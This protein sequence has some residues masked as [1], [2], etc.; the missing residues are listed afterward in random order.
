MGD[1]NEQ[2]VLKTKLPTSFYCS[3]SEQSCMYKTDKATHQETINVQFSFLLPQHDT[4]SHHLV[5]DDED[6][7]THD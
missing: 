6:L 4:L 1:C 3:I 5:I 2:R 7:S